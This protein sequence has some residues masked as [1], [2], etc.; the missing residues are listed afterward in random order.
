MSE[1]PNVSLV[2]QGY[3]AIGRGDLPAVLSL[4]AEDGVM[5]IAGNGP[6][7]GDHKGREAIGQVFAGLVEWTG[8]TISLQVGD[9]F[10]DDG[11]AIVLVRETAE[12]ARDGLMLDV[13]E[14]HIFHLSDGAALEFWDLPADGQRAEHDAFFA[15]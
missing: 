1:H 6:L 12:R 3:E 8:G 11:H 2:R 4:F 5:H 15:E 10:A 14:V 7:T 13:N 9:V